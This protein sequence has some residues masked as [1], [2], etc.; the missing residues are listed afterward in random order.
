MTDTYYKKPYLSDWLLGKAHKLVTIL[1]SALLV[2]LA[3][4]AIMERLVRTDL[5]ALPSTPPRKLPPI[6]MPPDTKITTR[7]PPVRPKPIEPPPPPL[8]LAFVTPSNTEL[9]V[10]FTPP[11]NPT[12]VGPHGGHQQAD[13][14]A[15][16][17]VKIAPQYPRRAASRGIEGFVDLQ[18]DISTAGYPINIQVVQSQPSGMFDAAAKRA[19]ARWKYRPKHI[20]GN[21]VVQ[22]GINTRIR[23]TLEQ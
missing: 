18:F 1:L 7:P 21:A 17:I 16:P 3:I 11:A 14:N 22:Q 10:D 20:D 23:F 13:S 8:P 5:E 15:L 12:E 19:L 6:S 2:T 4:L 9:A